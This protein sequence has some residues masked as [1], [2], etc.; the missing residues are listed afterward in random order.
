[1]AIP[2]AIITEAQLNTHTSEDDYPSATNGIQAL[3]NV[4]DYINNQ[5][6]T[7]VREDYF[8]DTFL[9][10]T[11]VGQSEYNIYEG[12]T[13]WDWVDTTVNIKRVN[14]LF[15]KYTSWQTYFT[16][17]EVQDP[18]I[19]AK[20]LEEYSVTQPQAKPF[21]YIQDR[22]EFIYPAP[23]EVITGGLKMNA[24]FTPPR[25]VLASPESWLPL[26][27]DKHS[28]YSIGMEW[29]I[30]KSQGKRF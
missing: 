11:V 1:M 14:K 30:F 26:Q 20:D 9:V 4:S 13:N 16:R 15:I 7:I 25:I 27:P 24:I 18:A 6:V 2:Q 29:Q 12:V 19:L 8:W 21:F 17:A 10:D 23:T 5:I 28:I 22:S 3:N